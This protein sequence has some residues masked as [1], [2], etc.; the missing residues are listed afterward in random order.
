MPAQGAN[1]V[2]KHSI[3]KDIGL[4]DDREK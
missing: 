2:A 1:D 4:A 3:A